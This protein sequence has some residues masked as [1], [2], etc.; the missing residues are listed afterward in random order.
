MNMC[1]SGYTSILFYI[2]STCV[3]RWGVGGGCLCAFVRAGDSVSARVLYLS[4]CSNLLC[5]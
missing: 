5:Y 2:Q 4:V 1:V 3:C